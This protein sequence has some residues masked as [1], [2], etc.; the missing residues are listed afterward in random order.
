MARKN[1]SRKRNRR[2]FVTIK[3]ETALSPST[4]ANGST[5]QTGLLGAV[6]AEDLYVI[7]IDAEWSARG[8]VAG[9]G[10]L[11]VGFAHSDLSATE[12]SECLDVSMTDP[13]NIIDRERARRPVREAGVFRGVADAAE[14]QVLNDGKSI[15]TRMGFMI[16]D[17]HNP[18]MWVRNKSG[19]SL[20]NTN[21][22]VIDCNGRIYGRW[23]R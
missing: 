19:A 14:D 6:L 2:G 11:R 16:G 22:L 1:H 4:L 9:E 3:F 13:D 17:G 5:L 18:A 10:P 21:A 23:S 7:S 12:I 15:R 20:S 8:Q